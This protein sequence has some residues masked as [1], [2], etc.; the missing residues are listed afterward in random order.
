[1]QF[2]LFSLTLH[3]REYYGYCKVNSQRCLLV[4]EGVQIRIYNIDQC[5]TM[6]K[7]KH[8][9]GNP[10][11]ACFLKGYEND[12]L[13]YDPSPVLVVNF[14]NQSPHLSALFN[15]EPQQEVHDVQSID[16]YIFHGFFQS[17]VKD[18]NI[19]ASQGNKQS[20]ISGFFELVKGETHRQI[21]FFEI[22]LNL[23]L[24]SNKLELTVL[25]KTQSSDL[26]DQDNEEQ[27]QKNDKEYSK[28]DIQDDYVKCF[29]F[30]IYKRN[31]FCGVAL[32]NS[33]L[34]DIYYNYYRVY[35]QDVRQKI[36]SLPEINQI[37][38]QDACFT[39][40]EIILVGLKYNSA[41][42]SQKEEDKNYIKNLLS[43]FYEFKL[44]LKFKTRIGLAVAQKY[45]Y[46][47]EAW[48][49][50]Q[51]CF[52]SKFINYFSHMTLIN[53]HFIVAFEKFI[54][55]YD[56][57]SQTWEDIFRLEHKIAHLASYKDA[58][59][60]YNYL[61]NINYRLSQTQICSIYSQS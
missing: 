37:R 46:A 60:Q 54:G 22:T 43:N 14:N 35:R 42:I 9:K 45:Q 10:K 5:V 29:R 8:E 59:N 41:Q 24:S 27:N 19:L 30:Q 2:T 58:S 16:S 32:K 51:N 38:F 1:M 56:L 31:L 26:D 21:Q 33:G 11:L 13:I 57:K 18:R 52:L 23:S 3:Y 4:G 47:K 15:I 17:N 36:N 39:E 12:L 44:D 20:Q 28:R 49:T 6:D 48:K 40:H 25:K 7:L 61:N 55:I 50:E 53:L 34:I